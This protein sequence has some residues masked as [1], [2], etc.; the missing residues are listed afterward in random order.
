MLD[1]LQR[2]GLWTGDFPFL[3]WASRRYCMPHWQTYS[4]EDIQKMGQANRKIPLT[5]SSERLCVTC[6]KISLRFYYHELSRTGRIGSSW[7]WCAD[8]KRGTHSSGPKLSAEFVFTDPHEN[9]SSE[10]FGQL[11]RED[12]YDHLNGVW[13]KGALPQRFELKTK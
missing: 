9:L 13:E 7:H 1:D 10:Q 5:D 4:S 3:K 12:W 8:C 6:N 11:E 2:N